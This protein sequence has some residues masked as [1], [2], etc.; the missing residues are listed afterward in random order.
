MVSVHPCVR[1]LLT[2]L[3]PEVLHVYLGNMSGLLLLAVHQGQ[4]CQVFTFRKPI[5]G[6]GADEPQVESIAVGMT[7]IS[8]EHHICAVLSRTAC[9]QRARWNSRNPAA[10]SGR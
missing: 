3:L 7:N 9:Q 4:P 10:F 2:L 5:F 1:G 8:H 6:H